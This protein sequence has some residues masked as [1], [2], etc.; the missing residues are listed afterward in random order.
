MSE[1]AVKRV[2]KSCFIIATV[3]V[4]LGVLSF[5]RNKC[6]NQCQD[7]IRTKKNLKSSQLMTW[8]TKSSVFKKLMPEL[9]IPI[10]IQIS[11]L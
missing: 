11:F 9:S 6:Q 3:M 1:S 10:L 5:F 2:S 7:L 8:P 4:F